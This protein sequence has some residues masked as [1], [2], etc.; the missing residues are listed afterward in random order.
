MVEGRDFYIARLPDDHLLFSAYFDLDG[1]AP[2]GASSF[3]MFT[4]LS[5]YP[6]I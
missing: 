1:G 6:E 4:S 3:G 2:R 5:D